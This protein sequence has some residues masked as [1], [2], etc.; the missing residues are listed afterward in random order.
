MKRVERWLMPGERVRV[1]YKSARE[2]K[3]ATVRALVFDR[4]RRSPNP[5]YYQITCEGKENPRYYRREELQL[6]N[7]QGRSPRPAAR[8]AKRSRP[9]RPRH[10]GN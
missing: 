1:W 4:S 8:A 9:A 3:L 5:A 2:W 6:L 7:G 10:P